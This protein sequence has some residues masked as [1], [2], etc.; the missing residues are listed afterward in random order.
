MAQ[1]SYLHIYRTEP[2]PDPAAALGEILRLIAPVGDVEVSRYL[3]ADRSWDRL[4]AEV[5]TGEPPDW[6]LRSDLALEPTPVA[7]VPG[8]YQ[9]PGLLG[10]SID[11]RQCD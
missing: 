7:A 3:D 11:Y 8:L 2:F 10:I 5:E 6:P 1:T 4:Q 9:D